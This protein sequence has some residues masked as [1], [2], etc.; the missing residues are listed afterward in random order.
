MLWSCLRILFYSPFPALR[1][2][3]LRE[4]S[5]SY[6]R[7]S[8]PWGVLPSQNLW[9][10]QLS[11]QFFCFRSC[12]WAGLPLYFS[13]SVQK[14]WPLVSLH[15]FF[16]VLQ[17]QFQRVLHGCFLRLLQWAEICRRCEECECLI[18]DFL[19]RF[20]HSVNFCLSAHTRSNS[21]LVLRVTSRINTDE[22][23]I[24]EWIKWCESIHFTDIKKLGW[25]MSP[26]QT[27]TTAINVLIDGLLTLNL[28]SS[29]IWSP[30]L[31]NGIKRA[32]RR[33]SCSKRGKEPAF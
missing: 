4:P 11:V 13:L 1:T 26:T 33:Q 30:R 28:H 14:C 10:S 9:V 15:T 21:L 6:L 27:F 7:R 12:L 31:E 32:L 8:R 22:Q 19:S 3:P 16:C 23:I 5:P 2:L 24:N 20:L 25:H 18:F 17:G 29:W